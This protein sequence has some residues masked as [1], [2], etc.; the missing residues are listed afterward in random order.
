MVRHWKCTIGK[1]LAPAES[2]TRS[3]MLRRLRPSPTTR[4]LPLPRLPDELLSASQNLALPRQ[5][6]PCSREF[7]GCNSSPCRPLRHS[8]ASAESSQSIHAG[9]VHWHEASPRPAFSY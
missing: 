3:E 7:A 8:T 2:E 6:V 1:R 5:T 4:G 9:Y